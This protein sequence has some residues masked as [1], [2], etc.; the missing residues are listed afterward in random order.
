MTPRKGQHSKVTA[1]V[2]QAQPQIGGQSG[3]LEC[4]ICSL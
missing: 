3:D 2:W 1:A 4:H